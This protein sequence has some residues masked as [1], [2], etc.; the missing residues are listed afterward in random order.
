MGSPAC[1][2]FRKETSRL[3]R[4]PPKPSS[5]HP[6]DLAARRSRHPPQLRLSRPALRPSV[7][8]GA[9][10]GLER[11]QGTS[12]APPAGPP[13]PARPARTRLTPISLFYCLSKHSHRE[14]L[15]FSR[16]CKVLRCRCACQQQVR[17][18]SASLIA[19][20]DVHTAPP[21]L[22]CSASTSPTACQAGQC[23]CVGLETQRGGICGFVTRR[24]GFSCPR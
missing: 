13:R 8:L 12:A 6:W 10:A 3:L 23:C 22:L 11:G 16:Y 9:A 15:H 14:E 18:A 20:F 7:R 1:R 5:R 17:S 24:R 4:S 21:V 2:A 19:P